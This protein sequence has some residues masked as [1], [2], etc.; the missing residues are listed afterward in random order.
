MKKVNY[1]FVEKGYQMSLYWYGTED[2]F[3][4][5]LNKYDKAFANCSIK[6]YSFKSQEDVEK[7]IEAYNKF[8]EA[9]WEP[10]QDE[11]TREI[12]AKIMDQCTELMNSLH[13]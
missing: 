3:N 4:E 7:F 12:N 13:I 8:L 11:A 2:E 9:A 10:N 1:I 5:E 6:K